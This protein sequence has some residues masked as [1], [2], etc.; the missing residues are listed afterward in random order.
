MGRESARAIMR[1]W[2]P[3]QALPTPQ[4]FKKLQGRQCSS[5]GRARGQALSPN[6]RGL[7]S[8]CWRLGCSAARSPATATRGDSAKTTGIRAQVRYA[9][10]N[11][12]IEVIKGISKRPKKG[13]GGGRA[14]A[15]TG[16]DSSISA[17]CLD[18][19][20]ARHSSLQ[21]PRTAL[22]AYIVTALFRRCVLTHYTKKGERG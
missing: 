17:N 22:A 18:M 8:H 10:E 16:R 9:N 7:P 20:F 13:R 21:Q 6:V 11:S 3:P 1:H 2:N 4:C 19:R 14:L 15:S 5:A 12:F